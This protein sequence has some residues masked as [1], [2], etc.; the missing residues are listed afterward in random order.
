MDID[1]YDGPVPMAAWYAC[2]PSAMYDTFFRATTL[3][4]E[5]D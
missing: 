4:Y 5:N 2:V 1:Y 3:A